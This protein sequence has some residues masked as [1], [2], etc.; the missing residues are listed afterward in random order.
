MSYDRP[1]ANLPE[2]LWL[3]PWKASLKSTMLGLK[4][5]SALSP[6]SILGRGLVALVGAGIKMIPICCLFLW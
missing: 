1:I 3:I 4:K 2:W 6:H 5:A